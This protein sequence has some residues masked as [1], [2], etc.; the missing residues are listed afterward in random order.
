VLES[1]SRAAARQPQRA[2]QATQTSS[3]I[4]I[5]TAQARRRNATCPPD[6][7]VAHVTNKLSGI[8]RSDGQ[9]PPP[10]TELSIRVLVRTE[11][12]GKVAAFPNTIVAAAFRKCAAEPLPANRAGS[13]GIRAARELAGYW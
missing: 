2:Y 3:G 4:S 12:V 5:A 11:G 6:V 1:F 9:K 7:A 10:Y 8:I 13:I